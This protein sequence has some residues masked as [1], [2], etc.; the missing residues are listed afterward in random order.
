MKPMLA[1]PLFGDEVAPRFCV[2]D[3]VLLTE[4]DDSS[5]ASSGRLLLAGAPWQERL[6]RLAAHGVTVLLCGGFNRLFMPMARNLGIQVIWGLAGRVDELVDAYRRGELEQLCL[7][8][9]GGAIRRTVTGGAGI[10]SPTTPGIPVIRTDNHRASNALNLV[11]IGKDTEM[12]NSKLIAVAAEDDRGLD[13]EVSAHFGRC[14]AYVLAQVDGGRVGDARVVPNPYFGG[15]QPGVMPQFI[16][17]LGANVILAGGMGPRAVQMFH[18]FGIEVATGAV[19]NVRKVLEAYLRGEVR[20]TVPC[21][22]DHQDS[23]GGHGGGA[24]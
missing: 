12:T 10:G 3:E 1:I 24:R 15:H 4:V 17:Q 13:G 18:G 16:N 14:P 7:C 9:R 22:H 11:P 21:A 5:V 23:C 20:G 19:G 6:S 8:P 2:A